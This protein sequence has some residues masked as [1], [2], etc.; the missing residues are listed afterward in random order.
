MSSEVAIRDEW[1]EK[2]LEHEHTDDGFVHTTR[3]LIKNNKG[4]YLSLYDTR[5]EHYQLPGGKVDRGETIEEGMKR[6]VEEEIGCKVK[7]IKY[8]G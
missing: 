2:L 7:K 3:A 5:F 8:L 1:K 4:E 6:E